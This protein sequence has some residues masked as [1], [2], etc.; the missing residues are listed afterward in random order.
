[1]EVERDRG[2]VL[3]LGRD[4]S[5]RE[6]HAGRR[7]LHVAPV[8]LRDRVPLPFECMVEYACL[9]LAVLNPSHVLLKSYLAV[10]VRVYAF[11]KPT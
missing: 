11:H 5:E 6:T 8:L 3:G 10:R 4:E 7:R 1:M 2:W 9:P